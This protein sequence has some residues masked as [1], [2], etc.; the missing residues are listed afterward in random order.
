M[1]L[2][3]KTA[4]G[5]ILDFTHL[6]TDPFMEHWNKLC[7]I[8]YVEDKAD[9]R[10]KLW[11]TELTRL[12]ETDPTNKMMAM[13]YPDENTKTSGIFIPTRSRKHK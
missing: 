13:V 4:S 10:F 1:S 8:E 5:G 2:V 3:E 11:G 9:Y 6:Q 12:F 7:I